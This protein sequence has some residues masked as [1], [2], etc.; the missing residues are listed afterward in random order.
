M[1]SK[2]VFKHKD[3][4]VMIQVFKG[5]SK[6]NFQKVKRLFGLI[7]TCS[8]KLENKRKIELNK[9]QTTKSKKIK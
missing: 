7:K 8:Q 5:I 1:K 4:Q 2:N 6:S 3:R 9:Q